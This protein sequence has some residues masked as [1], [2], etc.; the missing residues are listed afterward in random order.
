[1]KS[2]VELFAALLALTGAPPAVAQS[3]G[4][5]A[6]DEPQGGGPRGS[7]QPAPGE[8]RF[9]IVGTAEVSDLEGLQVIAQG[10]PAG[11]FAEVTALESGRTIVVAAA[12]GAQ[13]NGFVTLSPGA[14]TALGLQNREGG[15]RVRRVRP[16]PDEIVRVRNGGPVP[17]R[18]DAPA[19]LLTALR[20]KMAL[21]PSAGVSTTPVALPP[22]SARHASAAKPQPSRS[23]APTVPPRAKPTVVA[24]PI[25]SPRPTAVV[26]SPERRPVAGTYVQIAA[27]SDAGRAAVLARQV[28]GVVEPHGALYRVHLGPFTG[29]G[30]L[31]RG[32]ARAASLGYRDTQ[33]VRINP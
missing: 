5:A 4:V 30:A 14:A 19:V 29:A 33:T 16:S 23:P 24:K 18:D 28:G 11:G 17:R 25:G 1:M 7:S 27:L 20:R 13:R 32:R 31:A 15:V 26:Q 2:H 10:L 3:G 21:T 12:G 6:P 9:D 22:L 8:E